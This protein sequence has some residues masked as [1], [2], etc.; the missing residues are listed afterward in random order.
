MWRVVDM[1]L[2]AHSVL[3]DRYQRRELTVT[4]LV[5]AL[6]IIGTGLAFIPGDGGLQVGPIEAP[7]RVWL[8]VLTALIFFLALV[9]WKV[10]WHRKTWM[11]QD[12]VSRLAELKGQ[13]RTVTVKADSADTVPVNL[14]GLYHQVMSSIPA[15]P[16]RQFISMKAK[17]HRK[18]LVSKLIDSHKGAPVLFLRILAVWKGLRQ[19][20]IEGTLNKDRGES[21]EEPPV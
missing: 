12:A 18:V 6:S 5:I 13:F 9:E 19:Q 7:L 20:Q 8:G 10:D 15:I 16:E 21:V 3:R 14:Q 1:S 11:H 2:S 17:H 4:L